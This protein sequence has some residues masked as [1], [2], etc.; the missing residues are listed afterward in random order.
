MDG[1]LAQLVSQFLASG[2]HNP[3]E[4]GWDALVAIG[5]MALA[6]ATFVAVAFP[7]WSE[8]RARMR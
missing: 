1:A 3:W 7:I 8:R 2:A 4:W 5:T 6:L